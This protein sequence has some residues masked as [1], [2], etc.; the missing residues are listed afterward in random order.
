MLGLPLAAEA[1]VHTVNPQLRIDYRHIIVPH[2]CSTGKVV[3]DKGIFTNVIEQAFIGLD[4]RS[5]CD[6][7]DIEFPCH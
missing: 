1:H 2:A 3:S 7:F 4:V 5:R 6:F